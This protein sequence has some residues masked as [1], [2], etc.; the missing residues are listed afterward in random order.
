MIDTPCRRN[1][2]VARR[3]LALPR[4]EVIDTRRG[5]IEIRPVPRVSSLLR[6]PALLGLLGLVVPVAV[7]SGCSDRVECSAELTDGKATFKGAV[8]GK[9][10]QAR[11]DREAV[12]DACRQKCAADKA[13]MLDACA[14]RCVAD[15]D[16][17]K[18]RA[19]STCSDG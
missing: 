13:E 19:T 7:G 14:G 3:G 8:Q 5:T 4:Q 1:G 2:G 16:A 17:G 15:V 6:V 9:K 10:G 18:L 11:L 12:R